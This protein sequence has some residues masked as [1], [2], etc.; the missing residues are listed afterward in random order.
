[1][2]VLESK[3]QIKLPTFSFI[4]RALCEINIYDAV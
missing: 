4:M 3:Q 2:D 1:M